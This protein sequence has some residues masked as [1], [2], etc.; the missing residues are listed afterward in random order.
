MVN[1]SGENKSVQMVHR[2]TVLFQCGHGTSS[3]RV[4]FP[5]L[6]TD[7]RLRNRQG[8]SD[9]SQNIK[10]ILWESY[11]LVVCSEVPLG[12]REGLAVNLEHHPLTNEHFFSNYWMRV[13][14]VISSNG[15]S[16]LRGIDG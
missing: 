10:C 5:C 3:G 11:G 13:H 16:N 7:A 9:V 4:S 2:W 1:I 15:G 6:H 14:N 8:A 12:T